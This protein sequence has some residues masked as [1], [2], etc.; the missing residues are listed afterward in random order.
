MSSGQILVAE[1][2]GVTVIRLKGDVRLNL[3]ITFDDFIGSMLA[4]PPVR[5]VI[6]DLTRAEGVD[7]TTLGLMA[8][9]AMGIAQHGGERP[10][11]VA[12]DPD[13]LRLLETMGFDEIFELSTRARVPRGGLHE[14][15]AATDD[16]EQVRAKVVE[17]HRILMSLNESNEVKFRGLVETLEGRDCGE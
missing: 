15:P 5:P 6:F 1:H 9:I 12:N 16:E 3:C 13:M 10:V 4:H 17:A 2:E 14:L 11:V 8:K 7:S